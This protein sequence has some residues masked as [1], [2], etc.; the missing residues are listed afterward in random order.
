[1]ALLAIGD[2]IAIINFAISR[3]VSPSFHKPN[4]DEPNIVA[5]N[6]APLMV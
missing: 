3:D 4:S 1:L 2:K 5:P 6:N